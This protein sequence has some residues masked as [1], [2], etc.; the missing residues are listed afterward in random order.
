[1]PRIAGVD[2]PDNKPVRVALQ[3]IYGVGPKVALDALKAIGVEPGLRASKLTDDEL[4]RLGSH[5][6]DEYVVEGQLR[7][8]VSQN[9]AR[10]RDIRCYRS[11]SPFAGIIQIRFKGRCSVRTPSQPAPQAPLTNRIFSW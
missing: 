5:L 6:E 7:R 4:S 8:Q 3:Y 1:M 9:V 11:V 10:L 2:I